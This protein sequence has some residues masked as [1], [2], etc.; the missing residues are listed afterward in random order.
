MESD[1]EDVVFENSVLH[2]AL[3]DCGITDLE[4]ETRNSEVQ[5]QEINGHCPREA[6]HKS[7]VNVS[8]NK[9]I[10][11]CFSPLAY[12]FCTPEELLQWHSH[13]RYQT[14][15]RL[16]SSP[17]LAEEDKS[18][19]QYFMEEE[20]PCSDLSCTKRLFSLP[21]IGILLLTLASINLLDVPLLV[22]PWLTL[23]FSLVF[24]F[25]CLQSH[26][27]WLSVI[28]VNCLVLI[29][30]GVTLTAVV[31][32]IKSKVLSQLKNKDEL[33]K[34]VEVIAWELLYLEKKCLRLLQ[35]S[36]LV[37][38]GFTF[39]T[40][41]HVASRIRR[42]LT[43]VTDQLCPQLREVMF[44]ENIALMAEL[45]K[46]VVKMM[47]NLPMICNDS[48]FSTLERVSLDQESCDGME[49][50][51]PGSGQE[52][53]IT[54]EGE[55]CDP[56]NN[57]AAGDVDG[58]EDRRH[59]DVIPLAK[60]SKSVALLHIYI[61]GFLRRLALCFYVQNFKDKS[62]D[63]YTATA[64]CV[65]HSIK[66][67]V[68]A[69][70]A[71]TQSHTF[72]RAIH[73]SYSEK[74]CAKMDRLRLN[75]ELRNIYAHLNN[76]DLQLAS[77]TRRLRGVV[78]A[79][80]VRMEAESKSNLNLGGATAAAIDTPLDRS[81]IVD[82]L[83][84]V[85][86]T[87]EMCK[88]CYEEAVAHMQRRLDLAAQGISTRPVQVPATPRKKPSSDV[89]VIPHVDHII[90]DE[91]F[92]ATTSAE[93]DD[94]ADNPRR[95][96]LSEES[97]AKEASLNENM[98]RFKKELK[99]VVKKIGVTHRQREEVALARSRDI[100]DEV[101][102]VARHNLDSSAIL[103]QSLREQASAEALAR[104]WAF[105]GGASVMGDGMSPSSV[106]ADDQDQDPPRRPLPV[107]FPNLNDLDEGAPSQSP[108]TFR[109]IQR[110]LQGGAGSCMDLSLFPALFPAS[111]NPDECGQDS[112]PAGLLNDVDLSSQSSGEAQP[113]STTSNSESPD[114][115]PAVKKTPKKSASAKK[116]KTPR[117]HHRPQARR[118]EFDLAMNVSRLDRGHWEKCKAVLHIPADAS[119]SG[120]APSTQ[121]TS[122]STGERNRDSEDLTGHLEMSGEFNPLGGGSVGGE[123]NLSGAAGGPLQSSSSSSSGGLLSSQIN[124]PTSVNPEREGFR[125]VGGSYLSRHNFTASERETNLYHAKMDYTSS[126]SSAE[127]GASGAT[128]GRRAGILN[129]ASS[130]DR[131]DVDSDPNEWVKISQRQVIT[132]HGSKIDILRQK[133]VHVGDARSSPPVSSSDSESSFS[134]SLALLA[135]EKA[136]GM[137]I[138]G[139][140]EEKFGE[141]S[142]ED[143]L[144]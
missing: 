23:F 40:G 99:T 44:T 118:L 47:R 129:P 29:M 109:P 62:I 10:T 66:A 81:A 27:F 104:G 105:E 128:G 143:T 91:V 120:S 57:E 86:E 77:L 74:G 49:G 13:H 52:S 113:K 78:I 5:V 89:R 34:N 100:F 67:F 136:K 63:P 131:A 51:D 4:T 80:E 2:Q 25:T 37:A 97:K 35:E 46:W 92:E 141:S 53:V 33:I 54:N 85:K 134:K 116:Q 111:L 75:N 68:R 31:S 72:Y 28:S 95:R 122:P 119:S 38:R 144:Y 107:P 117:K 20:E 90:Q 36:E 71:L 135:A 7:N 137:D 9:E 41:Q 106:L 56:A 110:P 142:D 73:L 70:W 79:L 112:K 30:Y 14:L 69:K 17:L 39:A 3:L 139:Q 26:S 138:P 93:D 60:L 43:E 24:P 98:K 11:N 61:S 32:G 48:D 6:N 55:T 58:C 87:L 133:T 59:K 132:A 12:L 21:L 82:A 130:G 76:L 65:E 96:P 42:G 22:S 45:K 18:F 102:T 83:Q 108:F 19:L 16:I 84:Q 124:C 15:C 127:Q 50:L 88:D 140:H 101:P 126:D 115:E 8:C 125:N 103:V 94:H 114:E 123:S 64:E 121:S 1:D